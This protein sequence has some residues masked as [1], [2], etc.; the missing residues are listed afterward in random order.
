MV[1]FSVSAHTARG[2]LGQE[3]K[4]L[5][6]PWKGQ[7]SQRNKGQRKE[8]NVLAVSRLSLDLLYVEFVNHACCRLSTEIKETNVHNTALHACHVLV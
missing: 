5:E 4:W 6:R 2:D 8:M 1:H 3:R 7:K